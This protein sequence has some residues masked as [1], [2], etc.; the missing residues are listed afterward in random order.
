MNTRGINDRGS[1]DLCEGIKARLIQ[2]NPVFI[3]TNHLMILAFYQRSMRGN[4]MS[5]V[6]LRNVRWAERI[7]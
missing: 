6:I 5:I 7:S 2:F 4:L 1:I 3:E